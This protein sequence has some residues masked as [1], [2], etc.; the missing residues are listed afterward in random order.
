MADLFTLAKEHAHK[1]QF[2]IDEITEAPSTY[3][4]KLI[5]EIKLLN[6]QMSLNIPFD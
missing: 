6:D 3:L 2:G 1:I 4:G 5:K